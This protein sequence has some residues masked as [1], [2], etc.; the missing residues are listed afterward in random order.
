MLVSSIAFIRDAWYCDSALFMIISSLL[1]YVCDLKFC[2]RKS[3]RFWSCV[4]IMVMALISGFILISTY[5][6]IFLK[7][8][9]TSETLDSA[10]REKPHL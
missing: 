6:M 3:T 1:V 8:L 7:A 4:S 2:I 9:L 10:K 5:Q